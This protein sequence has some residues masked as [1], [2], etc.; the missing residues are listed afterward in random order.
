MSIERRRQ[1]G[2]T[3]VE[4]IVFVIIV[5]VGV[6]GLVSVMNPMIRNSADPMVLKQQ[7]AIAES[8][9]SEVIHQPYTWCDPDDANASIA[10]SYAGCASNSQQSSGAS[11]ADEVRSGGLG[12]TFDNVADYGGWSMD[13]VSDAAGTVA[14]TGYTAKLAVAHA[15]TALG[16]AD[17]TAALSVTVTVTHNGNDFALTAY[18]FRYAP[19]Y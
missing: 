16:L 19:R 14:M 9:L 12:K 4:L 11:P 10:Q 3:L 17:D 5:G 18:R 2:I 1:R 6:A 8:L 13:D 7:V 15:G